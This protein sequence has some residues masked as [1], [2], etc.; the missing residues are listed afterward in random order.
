MSDVEKRNGL[1]LTA[2]WLFA[3]I[4]TLG[5]LYYSEIRHFLPCKLCWFQRILMYPQAILLGIA[6]W[7]NDFRIR[8]YVLPF[9]VLGIFTS[10]FHLLEQ[11][12]PETFS[13]SCDPFVPCTSEWIP[14]FPIPLQALIAFTAIT[15]LLLLIRPSR[16]INH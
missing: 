4:A 16:N 6:V 5:S 8:K 1:L 9:S 3:L 10:S 2:A 11:K 7:N 12:F 15:V 13:S 14:N